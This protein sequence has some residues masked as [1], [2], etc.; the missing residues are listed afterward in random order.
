MIAKKVLVATTVLF[1]ML[2]A[3]IPADSLNDIMFPKAV[4]TAQETM[5]FDEIGTHETRKSLVGNQ[6]I[7]LFQTGGEYTG[8]YA[9]CNGLRLLYPDWDWSDLR[10]GLA[11]HTLEYDKY[12]LMQRS[13][14]RTILGIQ[15]LSLLTSRPL[16]KGIQ[17]H[18]WKL[19]SCHLPMHMRLMSR[20]LW[21]LP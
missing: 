18:R 3:P 16:D 2:T 11:T 10:S 4:S 9:A 1:L 17:H 12:T 13:F 5:T 15:G 7:T 20:P 14:I 21:N 8:D 19:K 6:P